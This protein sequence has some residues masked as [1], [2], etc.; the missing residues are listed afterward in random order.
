MKLTI[1]SSKSK[2]YIATNITYVKQTASLA[3]LTF[4]LPWPHGRQ[5]WSISVNVG[6][7][8]YWRYSPG[9]HSTSRWWCARDC[10]RFHRICSP[11]HRSRCVWRPASVGSLQEKISTS[12]SFRVVC[13]TSE[14]SSIWNDPVECAPGKINNI[15]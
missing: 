13:S 3:V 10:G 8:S 4:R 9:S 15:I 6:T 7:G 5:Y 11:T 2:F 14:R 1:L 12:T